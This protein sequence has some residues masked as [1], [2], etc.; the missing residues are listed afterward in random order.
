MMWLR[1]A[2][3]ALA[4][5]LAG[6][7]LVANAVGVTQDLVTTAAAAV[8]VPVSGAGAS[9]PLILKRPQK[10]RFMLTMMD[11]V[12]RMMGCIL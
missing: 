10:V 12:L 3:L 6:A 4:P 9:S 8:T 7:A 11:L 5:G 1:L 2:C